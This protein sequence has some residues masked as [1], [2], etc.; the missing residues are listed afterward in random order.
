MYVCVY[1]CSDSE[2]RMYAGTKKF[3]TKGSSFHPRAAHITGKEQKRLHT[4]AQHVQWLLS[5]V[6]QLG[7]DG[8]GTR[9]GKSDVSSELLC[10]LVQERLRAWVKESVSYAVCKI[11]ARMQPQSNAA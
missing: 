11:S 1:L 10:L 2:E 5:R 3:Q 9:F 4:P 7:I 6:Q 8:D